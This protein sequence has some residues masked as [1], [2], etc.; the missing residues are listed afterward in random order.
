MGVLAQVPV[1]GWAKPVPVD[2]TQLRQPRR[3]MLL[4]SLAGP[5]TNLSLMA[6][7]AVLA[8]QVVP[9]LSFRADFFGYGQFAEP[10]L[11]ERF[12]VA[13]AVVN[14]FLGVFNLLPIPPLDGSSIVERFLPASAL[15]AWHRY[16]MYGF[17]VLFA[18]AFWTPVLGRITDPLVGRL[19][20]FIY[21]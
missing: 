4:V 17:A 14:L 10:G 18:V 11:P 15:P 16:R 2:P 7:A 19:L 12:L 1:I 21:T 13:F 9:D 5:A 3:H 20:E 6:L 8:R